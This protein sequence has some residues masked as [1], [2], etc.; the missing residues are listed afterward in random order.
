MSLHLHQ[1]PDNH[2]DDGSGDEHQC[3]SNELGTLL[4]IGDRTAPEFCDA[5]DFCESHVSQLAY[6]RSMKEA[7]D[8]PASSVLTTI[9][10][11]INDSA[12]TLTSLRQINY[13]YH[14]SKPVL[15]TGPLCAGARPSPAEQ[16]N[17]TLIRW[18][19]WESQLPAYLRRCGWAARQS[20]ISTGI[21]I[22]SRSRDSASALLTLAKAAGK[23]A[24]WVSPDQLSTLAGIDEI[25]W[26]DSATEGQTWLSLF[27][28]LNSQPSSHVW[29]T[30]FV[31]PATRQ[32]AIS[33]GIDLVIVK[34]GDYSLLL[35][36]SQAGDNTLGRRAA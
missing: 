20:T 1:R 14:A 31:T 16:L 33:A 34:P 7:L 24:A 18:H 36:R 27:D 26:D 17:V 29:I 5:Y 8:R 25:W 32:A 10:C 21:A 2:S 23:V 19:E 9:C 22:V 4:W 6:R 15:L 28:R 12:E 11:L 30:N 3:E 35:N 13:V